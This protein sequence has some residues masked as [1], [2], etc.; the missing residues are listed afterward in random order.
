MKKLSRAV[1]F[2][3]ETRA[4]SHLHGSSSETALNVT[5]LNRAPLNRVVSKLIEGER[6]VYRERALHSLT[7]HSSAKISPGPSDGCTTRECL[8]VWNLGRCRQLGSNSHA[9]NLLTGEYARCNQVAGALCMCVFV[10]M[11]AGPLHTAMCT[12]MNAMCAR[13]CPDTSFAPIAG[14]TL[15]FAPRFPAI[16]LPRFAFPPP[17]APRG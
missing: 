7:K 13:A 5:S 16:P 10:S 3:G 2:F 14:S 1:G 11:C 4:R 15:R 9:G 8:S 17:N 6:H 12:C